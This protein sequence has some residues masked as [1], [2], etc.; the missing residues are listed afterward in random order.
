MLYLADMGVLTSS[1]EPKSQLAEQ[2]S[3]KKSE[4]FQKGSATDI[5]KEPK[6]RPLGK[7]D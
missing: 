6:M 5:K 1:H 4:A 7:A 3:L 2:L